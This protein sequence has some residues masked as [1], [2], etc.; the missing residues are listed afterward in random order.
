MTV[1]VI[2]F[3]ILPQNTAKC[4]FL[5]L[6]NFFKNLLL[7][8]LQ[9]S[10]HSTCLFFFV[11]SPTWLSYKTSLFFS[12]LWLL[13]SVNWKKIFGICVK[14]GRQFYNQTYNLP[15]CFWLFHWFSVI[16]SQSKPCVAWWRDSA[17][18]SAANRKVCFEWIPFSEF[19]ART[20]GTG[21]AFNMC[22][23]C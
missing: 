17:D 14:L 18:Q 7:L 21:F 12:P 15:F 10:Y 9:Q 13:L 19:R 4:C 23:R 11:F 16:V 20:L 22:T 2:H 3:K 1:F 5:L 6:R 8:Q